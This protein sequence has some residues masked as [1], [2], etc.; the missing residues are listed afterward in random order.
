MLGVVV[1]A[2]ATVVT[3]ALASEAAKPPKKPVPQ[4][5]PNP[6]AL[7]RPALT[8][9]VTVE[10]TPDNRYLHLDPALDYIV[11]MPTT[12]FSV[13]GGIAIVGGRNVVIVGGEIVDETPIAP[14]ESADQ[15]YGLY[16]EDQTG[17]VHVE[18][19]WIHGRG[20]GQALILDQDAGATVQ[21]QSSRLV[22]MHPVGHVHTDGIQ[23]WSGPTR[24][25]LR[26]VT[27]RTAGV[28]IQTQPHTF[29]AIPIDRWEY[30]RV[31]VVQM[32]RDA[33]AL[34]KGSGHGSWWREIHRELWVKNLGNFAWPSRNHWNPGGPGGVEGEP[35]KKGLPPRGDFVQAGIVGLLYKSS[36][37]R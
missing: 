24:L 29:A 8:A 2:A 28:G 25:F 26:N 22:A 27:I 5:P 15:A 17:T 13:P 36:A 7:A 1:L 23:T 35:I 33:Y 11:K 10:I 6:P 19:L 37:V 18:G 12:P 32:T 4:Q 20:I 14:S 9:P 21:V 30:H 34:W 16:L 3:F 31:N